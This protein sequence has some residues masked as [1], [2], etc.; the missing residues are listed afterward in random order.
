[1]PMPDSFDQDPLAE[2]EPTIE[3]VE[4][5]ILRQIM[6]H[7]A[8]LQE[9]LARQGQLLADQQRENEV[10]RRELEAAK[11]ARQS[12]LQYHRAAPMTDDEQW[13]AMESPGG[14]VG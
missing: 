11:D 5:P 6:D 7:Q 9:M 10:L 4:D 2:K 13:K 3:T 1:M 8:H 12:G 14:L